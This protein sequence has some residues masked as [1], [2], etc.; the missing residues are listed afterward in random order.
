MTQTIVLLTD[1]GTRDAYAGLLKAV[2]T[3]IYPQAN[4]LDLT[5]GIE[6]L[7]IEQGACVLYDSY[8]YY[9][10]GSIFVCV[11]DPGVG[12]KRKI[13]AAKKDGYTFIGPDNGLL[14]LVLA[15]GKSEIRS[16]ENPE[17]FLKRDHSA[18][19]H[20]RDIMAPAAARLAKNPAAFRQLGPQIVKIRPLEI[21][22]PEKSKNKIAG[23]ILYFDHYGNAITNILQTGKWKPASVSLKGKSLGSLRRTYGEGPQTL[24]AV[25]NSASRLELALPGG[26]AFK[27]YGLKKGDS[28]TVSM[29]HGA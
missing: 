27:K 16:L 8:R 7:N 6:P 10:S 21:P 14:S 19:F 23:A 22:R 20:G 29:G 11:V 28:V 18:T 9:P 12:T 24:C 17:F 25:I 26:S 13:I 5:H 1:F 3:S 2:I 15:G 4:I